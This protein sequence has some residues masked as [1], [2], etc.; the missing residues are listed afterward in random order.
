MKKT[1]WT[2]AVNPYPDRVMAVIPIRVMAVIPMRENV[3]VHHGSR[4]DN[5]AVHQ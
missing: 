1:V 4:P 5:P 3:S 2:G